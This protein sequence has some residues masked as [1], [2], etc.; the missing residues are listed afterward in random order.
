M[1]L[2]TSDARAGGCC[3]RL[4]AGVSEHM[5]IADLNPSANLLIVEG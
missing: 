3:V 1:N 4:P 5:R 2:T